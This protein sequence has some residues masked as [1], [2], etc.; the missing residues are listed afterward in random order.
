MGCFA[1]TCDITQ[2]G[3]HVVY[4]LGLYSNLEIVKKRRK[5][6]IF[7]ATRVKYGIIKHFAAVCEQFVLFSPKKG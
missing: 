2:A 1:G 3:G 7:D 5:L 4:N 6:N